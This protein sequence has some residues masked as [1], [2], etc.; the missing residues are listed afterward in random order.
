MLHGYSYIFLCEVSCSSILPTFLKISMFS[1][2]ILSCC[3]ILSCW[4]FSD[5]CDIIFCQIYD[6]WLF[7]IM[8]L[9]HAFLNIIFQS[10]T[11]NSGLLDYLH[12][13]WFF[14]VVQFKSTIFPFIFYFFLFVFYFFVYMFFID[15]PCSLLL[16]FRLIKFVL[17]FIF[18]P[19]VCLLAISIYFSNC[20][21]VYFIYL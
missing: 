21:G 5:V 13:M 6:F 2:V 10:L 12:L 8:W 15:S 17:W 7:S 3:W 4:I 20:F 9:H 14:Y 19:S 11:F 18:I 16:Y 1:F